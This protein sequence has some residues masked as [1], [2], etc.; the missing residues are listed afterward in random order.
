MYVARCDIARYEVFVRK[1]QEWSTDLTTVD[2]FLVGPTDVEVLV[3][4]SGMPGPRTVL[5]AGQHGDEAAGPLWLLGLGSGCV[6]A[7]LKVQRG[8]LT[9]IRCA[10][11]E[12]LRDGRRWV[13]P[14]AYMDSVRAQRLRIEAE[15]ELRYHQAELDVELRLLHDM[16][17]R[18]AERAPF[19]DVEDTLW[20]E[21]IRSYAHPRSRAKDRQ[22]T[23]VLDLHVAD[24]PDLS[25]QSKLCHADCGSSL[26]LAKT[27]LGDAGLDAAWGTLHAAPAGSLLAK[28]SE[29]GIPAVGIE[30]PAYC[31]AD[32]P[33]P[34]WAAELYGQPSMGEINGVRTRKLLL[35]EQQRA[36]PKIWAWVLSQHG[37]GA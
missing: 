27:I 37:V 6:D 36:M 35:P 28:C 19:D 5:I 26:A 34:A 30:L 24:T 15:P 22:A 18:W 1:I 16:N 4:S 9:V 32:D 3:A 25:W 11:P 33:V 21:V 31:P 12:G 20:R 29:E 13:R 14:Q 8:S 17:R 2:R 7:L 10:N 23:Q